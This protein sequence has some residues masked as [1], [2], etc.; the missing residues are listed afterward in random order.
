MNEGMGGGIGD[1]H[2]AGDAV[3]V[4]DDVRFDRGRRHRHA[5]EYCDACAAAQV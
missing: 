4:S 5:D 1:Q 2:V 3:P